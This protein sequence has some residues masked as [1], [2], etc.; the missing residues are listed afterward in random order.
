M[1]KEEGMRCP[2]CRHRLPSLVELL[3]RT[4]AGTQC[5]HCRTRLS[6]LKQVGLQ[7]E[8]RGD[9]GAQFSRWL[10]EEKEVVR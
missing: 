8:E 3:A 4:E 9:P 2:V 7:E 6:R 5:P 10:R 1:L